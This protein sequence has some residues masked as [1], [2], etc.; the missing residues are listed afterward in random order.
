MARRHAARNRRLR[1]LL[2]S[3]PARYFWAAVI[4]V[5]VEEGWTPGPMDDRT[6]HRLLDDLGEHSPLAKLELSPM[7][8]EVLAGLADGKRR[9]EIAAQLGTGSESVKTRTENLYRRL[10]ARNASHAVAIGFR[11]GILG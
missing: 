3:D 2:D 6:V 7:E 8:T 4:D 9:D 10:G 5:M 11:Q 1:Q